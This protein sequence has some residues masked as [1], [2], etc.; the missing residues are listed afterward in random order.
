MKGAFND[1][2]RLEQQAWDVFDVAPDRSAHPLTQLTLIPRNDLDKQ[3]HV[4]L[5]FDRNRSIKAATQI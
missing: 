2:K 5:W 3:H 1:E 4:L